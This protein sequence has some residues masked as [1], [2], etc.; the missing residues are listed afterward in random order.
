[1]TNGLVRINEAITYKVYPKA[2]KNERYIYKELR[3]EKATNIYSVGTTDTDVLNGFL[4]K[5]DSLPKVDFSTHF[6]IFRID[7]S[8]LPA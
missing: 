3:E 8:K 1:M 7:Y 4:S 5:I 6:V 2:D